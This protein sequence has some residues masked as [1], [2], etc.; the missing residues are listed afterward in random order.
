MMLC[1]DER[2]SAF[3][4]SMITDE[5][6]RLAALH[7]SGDLDDAEF[8]AAK[9]SLIDNGQLEGDPELARL[10][11]EWR[12]RQ[13]ELWTYPGSP[14]SRSIL[15]QKRRLALFLGIVLVA[16][17]VF[18]GMTKLR[19]LSPPMVAFYV[20]VPLYGL[21]AYYVHAAIR[22]RAEP[23]FAAEDEYFRRR[24]ELIRSQ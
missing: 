19:W 9:R 4:G 20:I 7:R 13:S 22:R 11:L 3:S 14:P 2:L 23:Y 17:P 10:E 16:I 5:L 8:V 18:F 24:G 15:R 12:R 6:E 1:F 21:W